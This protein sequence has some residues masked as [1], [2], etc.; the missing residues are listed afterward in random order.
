MCNRPIKLHGERPENSPLPIKRSQNEIDVKN[1]AA[2][3][4][5]QVF[6]GGHLLIHN[7]TT[8]ASS[9][10]TIA[11]AVHM[12]IALMKSSVCYLEV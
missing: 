11:A 5:S 6:N 7:A 12:Q 1:C 3:S 10:N 2:W 9:L 4:W 8:E